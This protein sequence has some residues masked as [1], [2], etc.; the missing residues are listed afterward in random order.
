MWKEGYQI[1]NENFEDQLEEQLNK[2]KPLY[3]LLHAYVRKKLQAF[4]GSDR[5]LSNGPI[6]AHLFGKYFRFRNFLV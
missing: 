3:E 5:I 4:Y 1:E 2:I 6:P